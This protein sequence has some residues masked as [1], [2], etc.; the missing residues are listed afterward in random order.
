MDWADGSGAI[1]RVPF[2]I[3]IIVPKIIEFGMQRLPN[4]ACGVVIPDLNIPASEWVRELNNRS[5]DPLN[6]YQID[7]KTVAAILLDP[8]VWEDV[9]IWHTHPSGHVGPSRDDMRRRDPR[10]KYL[11]VSL[12]RGEAVRF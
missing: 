12:P 8:E 9:L 5:P 6:S 2:S 3:D 1:V 4:E 10:L 7:P 11:V